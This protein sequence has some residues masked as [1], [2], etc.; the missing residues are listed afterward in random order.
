MTCK[1]FRNE[2]IQPLL[3]D[4]YQITMVYAYWHN[5]KMNDFAVFDLFFR[6]NPFKGEYT[7][8]AGL[9]QCIEYLK[10]FHFKEDGKIFFLF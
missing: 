8:F 7:I 6:K 10:N 4:Y 2:V 1:L 5:K 9:Q 3:T